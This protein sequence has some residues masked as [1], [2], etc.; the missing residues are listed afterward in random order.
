MDKLISEYERVKS[1]EFTLDFIY[2][3]KAQRDHMNIVNR[4]MSEAEKD[5]IRKS[6]TNITD[7]IDGLENGEIYVADLG[8]EQVKR[9]RSLLG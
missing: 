5:K 9:L 1:H 6:K 2:P 3:T 7:L 4:D 8:E